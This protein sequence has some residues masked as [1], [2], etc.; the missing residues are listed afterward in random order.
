MGWMERP[1]G[2]HRSLVGRGASK[3]GMSRTTGSTTMSS[4]G[5]DQGCIALPASR[6]RCAKILNPPPMEEKNPPRQ[7]TDKFAFEDNRFVNNILAPGTFQ[8]HMKWAWQ[9]M[10]AGKPVAVV[11]FGLLDKVSFRNNDFLCRKRQRRSR[12][13]IS[14][15]APADV[16]TGR[17]LSASRCQAQFRNA[18]TH[19]LDKALASLMP[20]RGTSNCAKKSA[21]RCRGVPDDNGRSQ[22]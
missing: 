18:F 6:L 7:F 11:A 16:G 15:P 10:L 2:R 3:L 5:Y 13:S 12:R 19:N 9:Q 1:T 21:D 4:S 8:P 20:M 14:K 17:L 22:E